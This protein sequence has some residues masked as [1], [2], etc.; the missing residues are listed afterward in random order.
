[1]S[2]LLSTRR[3]PTQQPNSKPQTALAGP[4]P[5]PTLLPKL[6]VDSNTGDY[7][8]ELAV[9]IGKPA[10]NVSEDH[11]LEYVLGYTSGN[12]VSCRAAQ[13]A[14]SQW[15]FSKGFDGA[16][17]IGPVVVS[18]RAV[19]DPSKLHIRGIMNGKVM[20]DCPISDLVF[21]VQKLV[22]FLSQGTTLTPG[23]VIVTGTPAGVG[24]AQGVTLKDGDEF[25]VEIT[26]HVGTLIN[27]CVNE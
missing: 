2:S 15:C 11:A 1:M 9:I 21:S 16:C 25:A 26:P 3:R 12:D 4:W 27:R 20:Q 14:Q 24:F 23:T 22:S 10:K 18:A 6:T 7:E 13:F 17:P 5:E 19:P 8:S